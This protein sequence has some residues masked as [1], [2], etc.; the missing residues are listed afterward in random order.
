MKNARV[1]A[2]VL[3]AI[4]TGSVVLAVHRSRLS[5]KPS[6]DELA[7]LMS[8]PADLAPL[9]PTPELYCTPA[10]D[11]PTTAITHFP[12]FR[13]NNF[14]KPVGA[15]LLN[16]VAAAAT[17]VPA[18]GG[19]AIPFQAQTLDAPNTQD[20]SG[21]VQITPNGALNPGV[22]YR[23]RMAALPAGLVWPAWSDCLKFAD[24]SIGSQ[25]S[26][27]NSQPTLSF[28]RVACTGNIADGCAVTLQFSE[29]VTPTAAFPSFAPTVLL[30]QA[31]MGACTSL[32][33]G[34]LVQTTT[35]N[36]VI[37]TVPEAVHQTSA[38]VIKCAN[39]NPNLSLG[40]TIPV[41][42]LVSV[43]TGAAI[44]DAAG[45]AA[46]LAYNFFPSKLRTWRG[47]KIFV[48]GDNNLCINRGNACVSTKDCCT[49]GDS[50]SGATCC[51]AL[52]G[53]CAA[54]A[55]CCADLSVACNGGVCC[56][57]AGGACAQNADC[58]AG[59]V[60]QNG[61]CGACIANGAASN[62]DGSGCC[63]GSSAGGR[64]CALVNEACNAG[65]D[66]C[67]P[68]AGQPLSLCQQV[69]PGASACCL[70]HG[71]ACGHDSSCCSLQCNAGSCV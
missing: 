63:S 24:G 70:A 36:G 1:I 55:D 11:G 44:H 53:G 8:G 45:A 2:T 49:V 21:W 23:L 64:C 22:S 9:P 56:K 65:G 37:T 71:A 20:G 7:R 47:E 35:N 54:K 62:A 32:T 13:I 67:A 30:A 40:V 60:C 25:F 51:V 28:I 58:C 4:G 3:A 69:Q 10:W 27:Q 15:A 46:P 48:P 41:N 50:C 68:A 18:A 61:S 31:G 16:A 57:A 6:R 29:P 59:A 43:A 42:A 66:C 12:G 34:S 39:L 19:A 14:G 5:V 38:V 33:D 52:G 26:W 17:L